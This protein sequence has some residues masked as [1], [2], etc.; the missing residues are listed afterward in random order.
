MP[1]LDGW[2]HA[3]IA[4]VYLNDGLF[5]PHFNGGQAIYYASG[6]GAINAV[7]AAFSGLSVVKVHN[8]QH[9]FWVVAGLYMLTTTAA[10]VARRPLAAVQW[11]PV[12]FLNA[13][14]LH[15]LPPDVH[16]THG[17]Q[18]VAAP[19]ADKPFPSSHCCYPLVVLPSMRE[20]RFRLC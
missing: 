17:P 8:L 7:T 20:W 18:Q 15:N 14:P 6:F 10:V 16:W 2:F 3:F 5:Y 13:Y 19:P 1:S 4:R 11:L 12:L 9:I